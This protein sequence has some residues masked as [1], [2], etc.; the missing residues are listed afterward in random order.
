MSQNSTKILNGFI[1]GR[2]IEKQ[3]RTGAKCVK[4]ST[5]IK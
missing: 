5:V 4:E 3:S 2:A 1:N